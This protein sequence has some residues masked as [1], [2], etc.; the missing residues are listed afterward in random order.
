VMRFGRAR[1][2]SIDD[3]LEM[4]ERLGRPLSEW[5]H[6][7]PLVKERPRGVRKPRSRQV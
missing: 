1:P 4:H 7:S 6:V 2:V 5:L 3:V